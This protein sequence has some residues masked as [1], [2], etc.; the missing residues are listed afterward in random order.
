MPQ[1]RCEEG[2]QETTV[3]DA[4]HVRLLEPRTRTRHQLVGELRRGGGIEEGCGG[5]GAAERGQQT[6]GARGSAAGAGGLA[7]T[8][9]LTVGAD[10]NPART[11]SPRRSLRAVA[12]ASS[13]AAAR[14]PRSRSRA[15][16]RLAC[17]L[18]SDVHLTDRPVGK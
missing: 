18:R 11:T 12:R 7:C 4:A 9:D 1:P 17:W 3:K 5:V 10:P 16:T 8:Y 6:R 14:R 13:A 2:V 15:I